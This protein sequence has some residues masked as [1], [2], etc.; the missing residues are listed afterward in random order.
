M[1]NFQNFKE[2]LTSK[3]TFYSSLT[4]RSDKIYELVTK[5]MNLF[6]MF[7]MNLK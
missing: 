7:G 2:V 4:N 3:E 6:L 1:S 5:N